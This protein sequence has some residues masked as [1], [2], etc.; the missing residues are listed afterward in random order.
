MGF[1]RQTINNQSTFTTGSDVLE[2]SNP[3]FTIWDNVTTATTFEWE[4]ALG[5]K[6]VI[7]QVTN[8][9]EYE[10]NGNTI[11]ELTGS[12][13]SLGALST[14]NLTS[15]PVPT[16]YETGALIRVNNELYVNVA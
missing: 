16:S 8:K 1:V 4:L 3:N 9:L 12:G 5:W 13:Y 2:V 7:D 11:L 10:Y 6:L 15:F 14:T